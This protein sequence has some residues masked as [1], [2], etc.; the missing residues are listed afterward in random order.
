MCQAKL[1]L[2]KTL[3]SLPPQEVLNE[4]GQALFP[5]QVSPWPWSKEPE[6]HRGRSETEK[7]EALCSFLRQTWLWAQRR[8]QGICLNIPSV[9]WVLSHS[10]QCLS[11][12]I[13]ETNA[14]SD[15]GWRGQQWWPVWVAEGP[16]HSG[17]NSREPD[18]TEFCHVLKQRLKQSSTH[19]L[20]PHV[21]F[22]CLSIFNLCAWVYV[23]DFVCTYTC[24]CPR[25][26]QAG[27][28]S[29]G[30]GSGSVNHLMWVLGTKW[31]GGVLSR[32]SECS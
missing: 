16:G 32:H 28:R 12:K 29:P 5:P 7:L 10:S 27:A 31:G 25:R 22:W 14:Q 3:V 23:H 15:Q 17:V 9:S 1:F 18:R 20:H 2:S 13:T 6:L 8:P 24:S 11:V 21:P 4:V 26:P 30:T 19:T